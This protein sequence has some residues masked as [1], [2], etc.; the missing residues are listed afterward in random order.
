MFKVTDFA[1]LSH[2]LVR[3]RLDSGKYARITTTLTALLLNNYLWNR[4]K[5]MHEKTCVITI[6]E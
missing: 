1:A 2:V 3:L 4:Q 5:L 6:F